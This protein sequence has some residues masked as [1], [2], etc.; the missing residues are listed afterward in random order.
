MVAGGDVSDGWSQEAIEGHGRGCMVAGRN[1]R[2][3]KIACGR[4]WWQEGIYC[5]RKR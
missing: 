2:G 4:V 1:E 3:W 5:R